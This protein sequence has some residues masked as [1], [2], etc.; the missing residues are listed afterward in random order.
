MDTQKIEQDWERRGFSFGQ[1]TDPP[2]Q[3]WEDYVHAVDE[4]W[5][6]GH[7]EIELEIDGT[8]LHPKVGEEVLIK[9]HQVHSVRNIGPN[10]A[11]WYYGY[12]KD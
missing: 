8:I 6:L 2:G 4:L 10:Y 5:Q 7:G 1:F 11:H 9:A 12:P 3:K